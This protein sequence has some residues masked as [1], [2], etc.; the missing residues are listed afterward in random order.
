[1]LVVLEAMLATMEGQPRVTQAV[2]MKGD[3][4]TRQSW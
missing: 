1:M 3:I 4:C 2:G